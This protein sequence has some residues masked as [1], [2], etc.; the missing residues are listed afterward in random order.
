MIEFARLSWWP[1]GV[2]LAIVA[3]LGLSLAAGAAARADNRTVFPLPLDWVSTEGRAHPLAGQVWSRAEGRLIAAQ[4]YGTTL[5]KSR[6]ILLGENH[7]N[8]D[9]HLLQ[10]WA[11]RTVAKLRGARL[12]EGAPQADIVALEMLSP[13]QQEA[14][15]RFYGRKSK[16][17]RQRTA[18]DFGRML[19]WEKL[20]WPDYAIYEPIVAAALDAQLVLT[21]ANPTR[22]E[23]RRVGREGLQ[24][25]ALDEARRLA[26]DVD[27][28]A[29]G[30]EELSREIADSHCGMLPLSALANMS[31]VQRLR[32][33]RM[34]DALLAVGEWKGAILIAGNGHVRADRGVPWYMIRRGIPR[35]SIVSVVHMEVRPDR[36]SPAEYLSGADGAVADFVVF[37]PR[38]PRPDACEEMKRQMEKI[39]AQP[40]P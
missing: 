28:D 34:A 29:T 23:T 11:I 25:L 21:P 10:A 38:Q 3:I 2:K 30:G 16:V 22:E 18:G 26:L 6:F 13:D 15:D 8:A 20:G 9:H 27:L 40:K 33:A 4:Q 24:A 5:A 19:G 31:L 32:D 35:E 14:L 17:P 36:L 12:V 39:K 1:A 7:D 37:T